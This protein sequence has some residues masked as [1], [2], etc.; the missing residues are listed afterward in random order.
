VQWRAVLTLETVAV[1]QGLGAGEGVGAD[2]AIQQA[3]KFGI[4]KVDAV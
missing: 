1:A 2:N 3:G 4:G